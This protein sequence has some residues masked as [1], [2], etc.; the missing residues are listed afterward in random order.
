MF[1]ICTGEEISI[2]DLVN[3]LF[4]IIPNALPPEFGPPRPGDICRSLGDP[5]RAAQ[6]LNFHPDVSLHE[7]LTQTVEWMRSR[8][9][10]LIS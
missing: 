10:G 8:R 6:V 3:A 9:D 7:G 1:N 5:G 4:K 2:L